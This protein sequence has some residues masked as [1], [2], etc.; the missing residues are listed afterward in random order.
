MFLVQNVYM[1]Y[2]KNYIN[3]NVLQLGKI[4]LQKI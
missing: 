1:N 2:G 4:N 3:S